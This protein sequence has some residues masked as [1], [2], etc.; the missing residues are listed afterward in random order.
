ML[1]IWMYTCT[2]TTV[3]I[4]SSLHEYSAIAIFHTQQYNTIITHY[5]V[6]FRCV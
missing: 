3:Y 6:D 5:K 4:Q 1:Y 2:L